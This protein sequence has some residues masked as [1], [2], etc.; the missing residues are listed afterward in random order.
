VLLCYLLAFDSLE[1]AQFHVLGFG[2]GV[3]A[4]APPA[5]RAVVRQ[6]AAAVLRRYGTGE[7]E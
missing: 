6:E 4:V 5:L 1:A 3:E 2:A 7:A